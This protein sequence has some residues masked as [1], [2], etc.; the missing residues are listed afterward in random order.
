MTN[1]YINIRE[2]LIEL[3][4]ALDRDQWVPLGGFDGDHE[5][6]RDAIGRI[7]ELARLNFLKNPLIKRGVNIMTYYVFGRGVSISAKDDT[8]ND[9][10]DAFVND[11]SNQAELTSAIARKAQDREL[12]VDGNLFFTLF[13]HPSTGSVRI[14]TIPLTE[15]T[16]VIRDPQNRRRT[17]YYKRQWA[18]SVTDLETGNTKTEERIVYYRDIR[19]NDPRSMIGRDPV[20]PESVIYHVKVGGFSDW[21]FG[22]SDVYAAIDW[23]RAYKGFLEDFAKIIKSLA[24]FAWRQKVTGGAQ[25]VQAAKARLNSTF[26]RETGGAESNPSPVAGAVAIEAGNTQ[27]DPIKTAGSTTDASAGKELRLMAGIAMNLPD[28]IASGDMAQGTLATA[29]S[30]DRPTEFVFTDRQELWVGIF[31]TILDFVIY[32][33]VAAPNGALRGLGAIVTNE[34]NEQV[35]SFPEEVDTTLLIDFPPILEQDTLQAIQALAA[36]APMLNDPRLLARE[37]LI[38]LGLD[39]VDKLVDG[40]FP[41][42]AP[43]DLRNDPL[44]AQ[45]NEALRDLIEV[46]KL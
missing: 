10:I 37:A 21:A 25:G 24:R 38:R 32:N 22:V 28:H 8:I 23:A 1:E 44:L 36:A 45:V 20:D 9:V 5:L 46:F 4:A 17:M 6:S 40:M 41:E 33:A 27:L 42:T 15:I 14:A 3:E 12:T 16:G 43:E 35:V 2:R 34:Y 11:L 39:D 31:R 19:N 29:K 18:Q 26:G 13:V 7:S 30:L